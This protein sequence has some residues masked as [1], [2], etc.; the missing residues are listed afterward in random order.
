MHA[1]LPMKE[2]SERIPEKNF[3]LLH[4]LPF[5]YY[6]ADTLKETGLFEKLVI[7]TDGERIE[8]LAKD[9]YGEWVHI[10]Q[11]PIELQGDYVPMNAVIAHDV[12]VMGVDND[13]MQTHSTNPFLKAETIRKAAKIYRDGQLSGEIDTLFSANALKS[14]LYDKNLMPINHNPLVLSRTQDLDVIYEEN[15]NFYFFSGEAF[16]KN[17]H[18]IGETPGVYPMSRMAIES[19]D[20]DESSDWDFAEALL[21]ANVKVV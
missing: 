12:K 14:R 17:N 9:R 21:N 20:I 6:I 5:F 8:K 3:K 19:L 11:R 1:L 13:Y 15:S 7:D 4:G 16:L 2:H 10:I 18:R